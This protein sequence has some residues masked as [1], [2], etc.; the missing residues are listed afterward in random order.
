M[1]I[2]LIRV[3]YV[4]LQCTIKRNEGHLWP[5]NRFL[6][7]SLTNRK[8]DLRLI[9]IFLAYPH[10]SMILLRAGRPESMDEV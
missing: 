8:C 5:I 2:R 10:T 1:E 9:L 7:D 6:S 4:I 3:I